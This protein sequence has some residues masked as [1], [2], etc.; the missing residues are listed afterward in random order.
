MSGDPEQ[1]RVEE[2]LA[3]VRAGNATE[4]ER[5]ELALYIEQHPELSDKV[6]DEVRAATLG[7]GWLARVEADNALQ[8][9]ERRGA[10]VERGLG[11]ALAGGGWLLSIAAPVVGGALMVSGIGLLTWSFV[12]FRFRNWRKD[13]YRDVE[14]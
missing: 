14:K 7:H 11:L 10:Y 5:E 13:P 8:A 3:Q 4:T 6:D 9:E 12:R 2:L 1:A